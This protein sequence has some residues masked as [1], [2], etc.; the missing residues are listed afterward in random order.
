MTTQT[1]DWNGLKQQAATGPALLPKGDYVGKVASAEAKKTNDGAKDMIVAKFEILA[2]PAAGQALWN[3]FVLSPENA[4]ALGF[5]FEHLAA[6]GI[7][8]A[9]FAQQPS[10]ETLASWIVQLA[11]PVI[12]SVS[13]RTWQGQ[14][15]NQVDGV[16]P[17]GADGQAAAPPAPGAIAAPPAPPVPPAP[18]APPAPPQAP[19]APVPAA[20]VP[21]P[22]APAAPAPVAPPPPAPAP[23]A[24]VPAAPPPPPAP[25]PV[26]PPMPP[27]AP[28]VAAPV[29]APVPA[30]PPPPPAPA[31]VASDDVPF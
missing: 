22:V 1:Y 25:V 30:I 24:G 8:D 7:S 5:F 12:L 18:V 27:A 29:P 6:L 14:L 31:A 26:A 17:Y 3:N 11:R 19:A 13:H 4:N 2:G 10:M 20:P 9:A 16:R 21:A 28:P 15:R 23:A